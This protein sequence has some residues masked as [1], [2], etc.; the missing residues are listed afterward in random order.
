[1]MTFKNLK[2]TTRTGKKKEKNDT[3]VELTL[4]GTAASFVL[5]MQT[6]VGFV[7]SLY[8]NENHYRITWGFRTWEQQGGEGRA[9]LGLINGLWRCPSGPHSGFFFLLFYPLSSFTTLLSFPSSVLRHI[10]VKAHRP[11]SERLTDCKLHLKLHGGEKKAGGRE[12][13]SWPKAEFV[14]DLP[15]PVLPSLSVGR[16]RKSSHWPL[17]SETV[18]QFGN[19][20]TTGIWEHTLYWLIG[21]SGNI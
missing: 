18:G 17:A 19:V 9:T 16:Q 4:K 21:F 5:T 2:V 13:C 20:W 8:D 15:S 11:R 6:A 14:N 12:R 1:M 7:R 3:V 10:S